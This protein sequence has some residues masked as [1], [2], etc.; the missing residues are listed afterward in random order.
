[1]NHNQVEVPTPETVC[2]IDVWA[3]HRKLYDSESSWAAR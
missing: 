3:E 2:G 1:M